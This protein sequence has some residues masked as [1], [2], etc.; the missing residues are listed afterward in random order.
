MLEASR[1]AAAAGEGQL[2][3]CAAEQRIY[4]F[5][6]TISPDPIG[7]LPLTSWGRWKCLRGGTDAGLNRYHAA[8]GCGKE[9]RY[10]ALPGVTCGDMLEAMART[11]ARIGPCSPMGSMVTKLVSLD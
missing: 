5:I 6:C 11:M 9:H 1:D 4:C 10:G 2:V 3:S 8:C 7:D